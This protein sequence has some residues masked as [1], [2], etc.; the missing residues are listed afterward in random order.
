MANE[1]P[2]EISQQLKQGKEEAFEIIFKRLYEPLVS[3]ANEYI[4]ELETSKNMV[5]EVF[6]KLWENRNLVN[7][8]ANLKSFL[9]TSTKNMCISHLRHIKTRQQY[10]EKSKKK[11][12]RFTIKL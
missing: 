12:R 9:Y 5:Q 10:F 6:L 11:L 3:F 2:K 8:D 7:V 4:N 1:I